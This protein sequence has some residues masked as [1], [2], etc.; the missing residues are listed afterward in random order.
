MTDL[1]KLTAKDF[2]ETM[3]KGWENRDWC[4]ESYFENNKAHCC[5]IGAMSIHLKESPCFVANALRKLMPDHRINLANMDAGNKHD[6]MNAVDK[7]LIGTPFK[8]PTNI[9]VFA[10]MLQQP[11]EVRVRQMPALNTPAMRG[12]E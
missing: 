10:A 5:A 2:S 7:I 3:H 1:S 8:A 6:A 9:S 4:G 11:V 12:G